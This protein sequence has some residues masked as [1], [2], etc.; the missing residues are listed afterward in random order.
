VLIRLIADTAQRSAEENAAHALAA[1]Q[2]AEAQAR[3]LAEA[4][5][6]MNRQLDEQGQLL[7]LV[8]ALETPMVPLA[9]G[10]LLAPIVGHVDTRRAETL[11]ARMLKEASAQH[12]RLVVLDIAGVSLIDTAVARALVQTVRALQLLGCDVTISGIS[13]SV[14]LTLVQLGIDLGRVRT[15]RSPQEALEQHLARAQESVRGSDPQTSLPKLNGNMR[16]LN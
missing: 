8:T 1:Q 16:Q 11:T 15:A 2:Q 10:V 3:E 9:D 12:A 7:T 6:L 13:A 4:N 5:D 14:A